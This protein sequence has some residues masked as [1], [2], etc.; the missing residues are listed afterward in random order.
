M[1]RLKSKR[2]SLL[3][4]RRIQSTQKA[5]DGNQQ[6]FKDEDERESHMKIMN[7]MANDQ[8]MIDEIITN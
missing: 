5:R 1:D 3:R 6:A 7:E 4:E 8:K 2:K